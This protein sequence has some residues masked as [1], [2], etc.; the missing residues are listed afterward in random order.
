MLDGDWRSAFAP[1]PPFGLLRGF[2]ATT[3]RR[4]DF[5]E[6]LPCVPSPRS[7]SCRGLNGL[8]ASSQ[9]CYHDDEN[10]ENAK[11]DQFSC[12]H[13]RLPKTQICARRPER[14]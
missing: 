10:D 12:K 14:S 1:P 6:G 11:R 7:C 8:D 9:D 5:A 3:F 13:T 2:G 4:C